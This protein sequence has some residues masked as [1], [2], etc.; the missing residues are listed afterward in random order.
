[1]WKHWFEIVDIDLLNEFQ[2]LIGNVE[3][4]NNPQK[5]KE[6]PDFNSS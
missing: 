3:T 6:I 2:F 5:H 1:M 4:S